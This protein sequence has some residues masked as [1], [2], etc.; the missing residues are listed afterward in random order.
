MKELV[1]ASNSPRR[2]EL[3]ERLGFRFTV[4]TAGVRETY[5]PGWE[6]GKIVEHLAFIK[7]DAVFR[8]CPDAVVLGADTIVVLD[9]EI[10]G[11]PKDREDAFRMLKELSG[12]THDVYTGVA[13]LSEEEKT[14]FFERTGVTFFDLSDEEIRSYIATGEPM[15]KAGAYGI[16]GCGM[17]LVKKI[18][19]DYYTV[20][21]LPAARVARTPLLRLMLDRTV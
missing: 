14:C 1:L 3:L 6:P 16:Q 19:G 15:D 17:S 13:I 10:L 4:K 7:A 9:G 8:Q 12:R 11:K 2:K 20:V 18:D 21:G 5:D